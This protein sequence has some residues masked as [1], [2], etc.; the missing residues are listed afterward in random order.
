MTEIGVK[1]FFAAFVSVKPVIDI[2]NPRHLVT[3]EPNIP[4][5]YSSPPQILIAAALP[6]LLAVDPSGTHIFDP[7]I[8]EVFSAQSPQANISG[9]EVRISLP[10]HI[11]PV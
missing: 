11:A 7:S 2:V 5:K 1:P 10:T 9:F 8:S 4:S 6:S 3:A